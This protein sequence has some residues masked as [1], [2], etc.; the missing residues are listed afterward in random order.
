MKADTIR[1]RKAPEP[2][3]KL[4]DSLTESV[5]RYVDNYDPCPM[6]ANK[7]EKGY[8]EP[9]SNFMIKTHTE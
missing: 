8:G 6:C 7:T 1:T 9:C 5:N 2:A 3:R 4:L